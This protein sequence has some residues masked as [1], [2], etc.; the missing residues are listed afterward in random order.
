VVLVPWADRRI[1][2]DAA[3]GTLAI[4]VRSIGTSSA[5]QIGTTEEGTGVALYARSAARFRLAQHLALRI[6]LLAGAA[7]RRPVIAAFVDAENSRDI[8]SFG[9]AFAAGLGGAELRF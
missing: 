5:Q 2:F 1:S 8:A 3:L 9:A 7:I 6:D 4:F